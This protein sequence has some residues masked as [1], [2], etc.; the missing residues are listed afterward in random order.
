MIPKYKIS[1]DL[2]KLKEYGRNVQMMVKYAKQLEDRTERNALCHEIVRIMGSINPQ[3]AENPDSEQKLW[4]HFYHLAEY[5]I[6]IDSKF[7]IPAP[8]TMFSR[9]PIRMPYNNRR[10]R[11]RQYGRNVELMAEKAIEMTDEDRKHA[12][13][14]LILNIMKSHLKGQEKDSN[15]EIIVCD[16]LR[17][18][19]RKKL[20]YQPQEIR[21]YKFNAHV[22]HMQMHQQQQQR[23][24]KQNHRGNNKNKK[25]RRR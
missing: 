23:S 6:D 9:P 8:E 2:L 16:H 11:Y 1:S 14:S 24:H 3:L 25:K 10:S 22:A 18:M 7:S 21:F 19:T 17:I 13:V 15:A 12:L 4:D 20:D 5:D